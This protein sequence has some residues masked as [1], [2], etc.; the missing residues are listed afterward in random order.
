MASQLFGQAPSLP[1]TAYTRT[2]LRAADA[3]AARATLGVSGG[4]TNGIQQLNGVGI[5]TTL[6]NTALLS[7]N[8][9]LQMLISNAG[10]LMT[11]KTGAN[12]YVLWDGTA[13][14][15]GDTGGKVVQ[16]ED[17]TFFSAPNDGFIGGHF[18]GNGDGI[19]N[20]NP[21]NLF[22]AGTIP[23]AKLGTGSSITTKFLRGDSTWQII[24]G[25]GDLLAANNLNDV[26]SAGL[27]RTNL[28]ANNASNLTAGIVAPARLGSGSGGVTKYLRE[29]ATWQTVS[30]SALPAL[31]ST[32]LAT[33]AAAASSGVIWLTKEADDTWSLTFSAANG[34]AGS[35][36]YVY[37]AS[38]LL[39]FSGTAP[40]FD[41]G[42]ASW[43]GS[44][45]QI[46]SVTGANGDVGVGGTLN[47][48][49]LSQ[50]PF[51]GDTNVLRSVVWSIQ[52]GK[53]Y[54][55]RQGQRAAGAT[56]A[57]VVAAGPDLIPIATNRSFAYT[58]S[59]AIIADQNFSLSISNYAATNIV[60]TLFTNVF[61]I[62][63]NAVVGALTIP[64]GSVCEY[65]IRF[66]G[67]NFIMRDFGPNNSNLLA[68]AALGTGVLNYP[69]QTL[70]AVA[71]NNNGTAVTNINGKNI[72]WP[73]NAAST[74]AIDLSL[75]YAGLS[76][77][78]NISLGGLTGID[79]SGTNVQW[80]TRVYTNNSVGA[81]T[82]TIPASWIDVGN[83]GSTTI[84]NTNQGWLSV[85]LYP[86]FGTNFVWRG[87]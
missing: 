52:S 45:N 36:I 51:F 41:N 3:A 31:A 80:A 78:N 79:P 73:T 75:P 6:T 11:N 57:V 82:I 65:D 58:L 81:K 85:L 4:S 18:W 30:G 2:L 9:L 72:L 27:S 14:F 76:T 43:D 28:G 19:T 32:L 22:G 26:A 61:S 63:S 60:A 23:P 56:K 16:I 66:D 50:L 69:T 8:A 47:V 40:V 35:K 48:T 86:G 54:Y 70:A 29:D 10:I 62:S 38:G 49:N 39:H 37:P 5:N 71:F 74:L 1:S 59:G 33:N 24:A 53:F 84:Y 12:L 20:A 83:Y 68:W 17:G 34:A 42:L 46:F 13:F 87:K 7:S 64:A 25:G 44:G 67:T 21:T 77:N 55:L 15:I